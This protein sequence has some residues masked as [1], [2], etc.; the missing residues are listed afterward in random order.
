M[1]EPIRPLLLAPFCYF[2]CI[3]FVRLPWD[4]FFE[5]LLLLFFLSYELVTV[6]FNELDDV[7]SIATE[8]LA[9][10]ACLVAPFV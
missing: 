5:P 9:L 8:I 1:A 10:L 2:S 7:A 4:D 6:D 3:F